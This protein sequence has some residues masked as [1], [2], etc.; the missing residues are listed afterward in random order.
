MATLFDHS[1]ETDFS[2]WSSFQVDGDP[3]GDLAWSASAGM[4]GSAGGAAN[5]VDSSGQTWLQQLITWSTRWLHIRAYFDP[6]SINMGSGDKWRFISCSG[7]EFNL[8]IGYNGTNY[9]AS[10]DVE[11]DGSTKRATSDYVLPGTND[12]PH[13]VEIRIQRAET[14][15]SVDGQV[16]LYLDG[17][18]QETLGSIDLFDHTVPAHVRV[19]VGSGIDS[20][21]T[22]GTF[23][24][25]EVKCTN[26]DTEIGAVPSSGLI[27][28]VAMHNY[29][30][31][32]A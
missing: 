21:T 28:P 32:R 25:D 11:D 23:Y 4:A 20:P 2:E 14:N 18:L 27:L 9:F 26:D 24:F 15:V 1:M 8:N 5:L 13:F 30:R 12:G 17:T 3:I 19:G 7:R 22:N 10:A 31:N 16:S 6:N 29:R